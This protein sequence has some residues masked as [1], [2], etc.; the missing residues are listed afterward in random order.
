MKK[1]ILLGICIFFALLIIAGV[2]F[3][4]TVMGPA[5][6]VQAEV[7]RRQIKQIDIRKVA[8]G[9]YTGTFTYSITE[10]EVEVT[11]KNQKIDDITI[12]KNGCT[13][14]AEK[15]AAGIKEQVLNKQTL[16]VDVETVN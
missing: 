15:A 16:N 5:F 1:K 7:R 10:T 6:A 14:H 2:V 12:L 4:L 13:Q 9:V 3:Y 11:V 8:D